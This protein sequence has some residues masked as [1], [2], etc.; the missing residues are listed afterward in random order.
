MKV[1]VSAPAWSALIAAR[2]NLPPGL[3]RLAAELPDG[4]HPNGG[5]EADPAGPKIVYPPDGSVVVWSGQDVPLE[6][7]GGSGPLRWLVDDRPLPPGKPRRTVFWRPGGLGFARLA[8]IDG[9]GRSA[10][11]S[12]RLVP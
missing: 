8:V 7:A 10:R 3:Q 6:A 5:K 2:R 1:V 4:A 12:V 11:A 9:Q